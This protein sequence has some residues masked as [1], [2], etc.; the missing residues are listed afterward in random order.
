M[1]PHPLRNACK[2]CGLLEGYIVTKSGQDCVYCAACN[3]HQYNAPK[4][5]TGRAVR[6]VTTVHN[7]IKANQRARILL[8]AT[9]HCELCGNN[10]ATL[11]VGHML[12]VAE[13]LEM[14][15]TE[16]ELNDDDNLAAMCDECNLG[17]GKETVPLRLMFAIIKARAKNRTI[18]GDKKE[19][20]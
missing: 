3:S 20:A 6:T 13:G 5:E 8:R 19:S 1:T 4:V 16:A 12:S 7:G 2:K 9:G 10:L 17:L 11:H 18:I 14:G 15:L